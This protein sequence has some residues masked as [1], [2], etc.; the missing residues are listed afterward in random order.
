M[1]CSQ[2]E[3]SINNPPRAFKFFKNL[4]SL[5]QAKKP[6]KCPTIGPFQVIKTPSS[7]EF[8]Q[9][10]SLTHRKSPY[11]P[12]LFI[13]VVT[14][15]CGMPGEML[16]LRFD[17]HV[18]S[19]GNN[20]PRSKKQGFPGTLSAEQPSTTTQKNLQWICFRLLKTS[21]CPGGG[22]LPYKTDGDARRLA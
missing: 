16:K 10:P 11:C 22:G 14:N 21:R 12:L 2:I 17:C 9:V 1:D 6:F 7:Q 3:A 8:F 19:S 20:I 4:N 13:Q 15:T 18:F 5:P